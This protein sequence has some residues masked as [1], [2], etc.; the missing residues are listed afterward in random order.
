MPVLS[1]ALQDENA[2][3]RR[4]AVR[5]LVEAGAPAR[6]GLVEALDNADALVRRAALS[7]LCDPP[8]VENL[9]HLSKAT[10]DPDPFMRLAAVNLLVQIKPRSQEVHDLLDRARQDEAVTVRQI[11]AR[12][13]W[14]FFKETVSVRDRKDWDHEIKVAQTIPL[15]EDGWKFR[16]DPKEEGHLQKWFAPDYE[17]AAWAAIE[18]G[19]AWEEQ[20]HAY[21]GVAWYRGWFDLP[22]KPTYLAVE[23]AFGGVDEIAWLWINGEFV[24][25]HDLGTAGWD[26]PFALDVTRELKWGQRNQ[27]TVRVHDSAYAGGIWK[28]VDIQVLQ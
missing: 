28:P 2:V 1:A 8:S 15:P 19:S 25:Q 22:E 16:T 4:T 7:A 23:M 12:A 14:P 9:P 17:D 24:G 6:S 5:L 20:G 11:A 3:V 18:I 26:K 13:V 21:D 10:T 27:I